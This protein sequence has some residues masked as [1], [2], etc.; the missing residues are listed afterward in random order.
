MMKLN[1]GC[2]QN[3]MPGWV[4][5]DKR[6]APDVLLDLETFPWPWSD[7]TIEEV[8]LNHVLEH[9]GRDP[10]VFIGVMVEL[11]RVCAPNAKINIAVPHPRHDNFLNDPTHVRAITPEVMTLFNKKLNEEWKA[12]GFANSPLAL[13]YGVDFYIE[14]VEFKID[15]EWKNQA[16]R[17]GTP[18]G[19]INA[20]A[21][22]ARRYN[23][24]VVEEIQMILRVIK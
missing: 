17:S 7:S 20:A 18:L 6:G 12:G 10:E 3:P 2:G 13:F 23:S 14:H 16:I 11:Y 4:N 22:L 21:D 15:N 1:L 24:N 5:V 19:R 9:L 8:L